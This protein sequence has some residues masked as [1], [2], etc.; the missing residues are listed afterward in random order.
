MRA[1]ILTLLFVM[2]PLAHG[3]ETLLIPD[4]ATDTVGRYDA[5]TGDYLG[6]LIVDPDPS[7]DGL[8]DTPI[9]AIL[10]PDGLI[11]VSDQTRDAVVRFDAGG[12]FVDVFCDATDG[13]DNLRGLVFYGGDLLVCE[14]PAAPAPPAIARFTADGVRLTDFAQGF[15]CFDVFDASLGVVVSDIGDNQVE[16]YDPQQG[17]SIRTLAITD[18]PEQVCRKRSGNLLAIAYLGNEIVEFSAAGNV[19]RRIPIT[20]LGRG[21]VELGN[22]NLL[23]STGAGI[24]EIN[25]ISGE[26]IRTIRTGT[27]FRFIERVNFGSPCTY[28]GCDAG[29]VTGDCVVDLADLSTLLADFG[30]STAGP[31]DLDGNGVVDLADL[32]RLLS[33]FGTDCR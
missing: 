12:N 27:G 31:A 17:T 29:D 16:L 10:G 30:N 25:P 13:L 19:I 6:D 23:I 3:Q 2:A 4:A 22:H 26:L 32:S 21:V 24:R 8:L 28:A 1:V 11:Y 33:I 14:A 18:F 9:D 15:S 5:Q 7:P 20:N